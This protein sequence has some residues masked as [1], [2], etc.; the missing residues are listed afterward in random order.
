MTD[1]IR[2]LLPEGI[3]EVLPPRARQI[4][5]LRRDLLDLYHSWGY[6]LVIPPFIEYLESLLTGVG[7]EL[8]LQTFKVTDQLTGRMM[9]IRADITPQVAR[10]ASH[11]LQRDGVV[12]LSYSGSVLRTRSPNLLPSRSPLQ[13]GAELF[14]SARLA[15]DIE[16]ADLMLETLERIGL[17]GLHLD[18]GHVGVYRAIVESAAFGVDAKRE[19]FDILRRKAVTELDDF[20]GAEVKEQVLGDRLRILVDLHGGIE[21]LAEARLKLAAVPAVANC[22]AELE[23]LAE[24]VTT[25]HPDIDLYFDL[26]ELR[27]YQ[28]HTGVVFSAYVDGYGQSIAKGGRYDDIGSV[29]GRARPATGFSADLKALARLLSG[30][31]P[32]VTAIHAPEDSDPAL[33]AEVRRLRE[34]GEVVLKDLGGAGLPAQA[35]L[36]KLVKI[37]DRWQLQE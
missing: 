15:A 7:S 24:A 17:Q 35:K 19:L 13:I 27:G 22:I 20:I 9:G 29:F 1:S 23:E 14:G 21:V 6:E 16:I 3:E 32:A 26:G 2:W 37:K 34:T 36:R 33:A 25:A 31:A 5:L 18:L 4:E 11:S 28:Y 12:R 8:D 30:P 10:M